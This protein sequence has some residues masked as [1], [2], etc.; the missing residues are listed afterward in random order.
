MQRNEK[1]RALRAQISKLV[2]EYA[3]IA[4]ASNQFV[5]GATMIPPSGKLIDAAELKNTVEASLDGWLTTGRFNFHFEKKLAT[6]LGVKH[7]LTVNSG[8][9]PKL[10]ERAIKLAHSRVLPETL[11]HKMS[12]I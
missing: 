5:P 12:G 3:T 4:L 11:A 1:T 10:G 2:E 6:F 9:S 7:L 8:S